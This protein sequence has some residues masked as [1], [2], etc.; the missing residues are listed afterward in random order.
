MCWRPPSSR[1]TSTTQPRVSSV[2]RIHLQ[3]CAESSYASSGRQSLF[4][5]LNLFAAVRQLILTTD[6]GRGNFAFSI[7]VL[8]HSA[9]AAAKPFVL[10]KWHPAC[11]KQPMY[12]HL[13]LYRVCDA[14]AQHARD[15][16]H[17]RPPRP[18]SA[19]RRRP[20]LEREVRGQHSSLAPPCAC[21][22]R[23]G[24]LVF[25]SSVFRTW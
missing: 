15:Q 2:W 22:R 11:A 4:S 19:P 12:L 24:S 21:V 9:S 20:A 5:L 17:G 25:D 3:A 8:S 14:A 7:L 23:L 16:S 10:N 1:K 13:L 6:S 18:Q